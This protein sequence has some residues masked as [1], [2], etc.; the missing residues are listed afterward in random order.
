MSTTFKT[1]L[2]KNVVAI[3][4]DRDERNCES[5]VSEMKERFGV[6]IARST[7]YYYLGALVMTRKVIKNKRKTSPGLG[8]PRTYFKMVS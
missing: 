3:M 1:D 6:K 8:R 7:V 2:A 4:S 5:I